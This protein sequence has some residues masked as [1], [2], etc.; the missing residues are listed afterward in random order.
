MKYY[1]EKEDQNAWLIE[2]KNNLVAVKS[3]TNYSK[4]PRALKFLECIG[5]KCCSQK[6]LVDPKKMKLESN[7]KAMA[8]AD[9]FVNEAMHKFNKKD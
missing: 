7:K 6:K 1:I 5:I 3:F 8:D 2:N 4:S 9:N